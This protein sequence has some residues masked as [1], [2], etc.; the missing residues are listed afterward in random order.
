MVAVRAGWKGGVD[1]VC[2]AGRWCR[3]FMR[4]VVDAGH[5]RWPARYAITDI[6]IFAASWAA[7]QIKWV[8]TGQKVPE[9]VSAESSTRPGMTF[10]VTLDRTG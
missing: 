4:A 2:R 3:S 10:T 8:I 5:G 6:H 7:N 9:D 1:H